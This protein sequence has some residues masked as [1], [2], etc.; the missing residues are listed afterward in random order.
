MIWPTALCP[1][2]SPLRESV[3]HTLI[4]TIAILCGIDMVHNKIEMKV[5]SAFHQ[6]FMVVY[7]KVFPILKEVFYDVAMVL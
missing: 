7:S 3:F 1:G 2:A 5:H 4:R 6:T